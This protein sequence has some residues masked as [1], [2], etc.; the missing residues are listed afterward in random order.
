MQIYKIIQIKKFNKINI[1]QSIIYICYKQFLV[2][3]PYNNFLTSIYKIL[4]VSKLVPN[5]RECLHLKV[6]TFA[7]PGNLGHDA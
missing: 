6:S 7:W 2:Y 1:F 3:V 4:F 5:F